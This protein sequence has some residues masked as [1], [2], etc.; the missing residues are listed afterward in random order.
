MFNMQKNIKIVNAVVFLAVFAVISMGVVEYL[1]V[2]RINTINSN[3]TTIFRDKLIPISKVGGI[4]GDFLTIRIQ[5]NKAAKDYSKSYDKDVQELYKGILKQISEYEASNID[6]VEVKTLANLKKYFTEYIETWNNINSKLG[7]GIQVSEEEYNNFSKI[8]NKIEENLKTLVEYNETSANELKV[9]SD[10][11]HK[12]SF[13]IL[14]VV[15]MTVVVVF[16]LLAYMIVKSIKS[17]S[18]ETINILNTVAS[19]DFSMTVEYD[20]RNE[21][22]QIK[23]A[24]SKMLEDV[25]SMIINVKDES[26]RIEQKSEDLSSISEEMT[27]ATENVSTAISG[28]S[29]GTEAQS[30]ELMN[31][32]AVLNNFGDELE[33]IVQAI[34]EVD[35]NANSVGTMAV[36]S[37]SKMEELVESI[38]KMV[39]ESG[40]LVEN[41]VNLS[42]RVSRIN[43]ITNLIN[44]IAEQ[45]NLL[46]L[47]AAIEAARAGEAGKGFAVVADEIRKLAE[48][49]RDSSENINVLVN[50]ISLDTDNMV[51]TSNKMSGELNSQREVA[52][53]AID[54]FKS[55]ID[56][57]NEIIPKIQ[58][59]NKSAVKI[60]EEKD[61]I[62]EKIE[63]V[64]SIAEEI[65]ASS[66]QISA[67]AEEMNSSA[68]EV[69][70]T[71]LELN[72]MN[73][74]MLKEIE[75]FK[76]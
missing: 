47:N 7:L 58:E 33:K 32:N 29:K 36:D 16:I 52:K 72:D 28:V 71:A 44:S 57:I 26:K 8:S 49:S 45:T 17:S 63:G 21:F 25:K 53:V 73:R 23:K 65:S 54:S 12:Q 67:S 50:E 22:G 35:K 18:K 3:I 37:N 60:E 70:K 43:E 9:N 69:S 2:N 75:K 59:V 41:V 76:V 39:D 11:T 61:G 1:A 34:D 20:T 31:T 30:E 38:K 40:N 4:R 55:I 51:S 19:G 66:E 27:A 10:Q 6:D 64:S 5:V 68:E 42:G 48:Q 14:I 13:K 24:L 46:A 15:F 56:A 74:K 62:I